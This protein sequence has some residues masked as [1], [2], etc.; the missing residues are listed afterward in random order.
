M[1]VDSNTEDVRT[2][3]KC[4]KRKPHSAFSKDP[5]CRHGIGYRCRECANAIEKARQ[6]RLSARKD[7]EIL[8]SSTKRCKSCGLTKSINEFSRHRASLD[9]HQAYC[10]SCSIF[11]TMK[12]SYGIDR[13][14]FDEML[15]AQSGRCAICGRVPSDA[16]VLG[17]DHHHENGVVRGLLCQWCNIGMAFLDNPEWMRMAQA[18]QLFA[19]TGPQVVREDIHKRTLMPKSLRGAS[20]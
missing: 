4:G 2:C 9:G 12:R 18:H 20:A 13:A 6:Q 8:F 15:Q 1:L 17:V 16:E 7:H 3:K 10:R 11:A 14:K 19:W 5:K